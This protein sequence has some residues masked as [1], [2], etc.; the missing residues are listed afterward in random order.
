M[1][2][3]VENLA[4]K[5]VGNDIIRALV[6]MIPIVGPLIDGIMATPG[7]Q[8]KDRRINEF[9]LLLYHSCK[10]LEDRMTNLEFEAN[11][12]W[13]N[14]EEFYDMFNLAL[15][16]ATKSRGRE[17]RIMNVMILTNIFSV[18]NEGQ[19]RPEEYIFA[20]EQLSP[21]EVKI[22][23]LFYQI[24]IRDAEHIDNESELQRANRIDAQGKIVTELGIDREDLL[25]LLKRIEKSGFIKEI[26]GSFWGYVGGRFTITESLNRMMTYISNH[27]FAYLVI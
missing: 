14:T 13:A 11:I 4:S 10:V 15:E 3:F 5:Y 2:A 9:L 16:G 24:C 6:Q 1:Q 17:K 12:K 7:N 18:K 20:L 25:F 19:F 27:P 8:F 21:L 26:T 23:L 22:I